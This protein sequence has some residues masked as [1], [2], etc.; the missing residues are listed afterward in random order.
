MTFTKIHIQV[1]KLSAR[2]GHQF[3]V[4]TTQSQG[5]QASTVTVS[6]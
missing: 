3:V 6:V 1:I 4:A 5:S 2:N